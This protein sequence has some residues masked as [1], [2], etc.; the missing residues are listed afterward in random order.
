MICKKEAQRYKES[1][2]FIHFFAIDMGR[3][4]SDK[5]RLENPQLRRKWV[6]QLSTV[7]LGEGL[8]NHSMDDI[9]ALLGISKATLYK[10][11]SSRQEILEDM[12]RLKLEELSVFESHL[13]DESVPFQERYFNAIQSASLLLAGISNQFLLEVKDMHNEL[14]GGIK[15]FQDYALHLAREFYRSGVEQGILHDLDPAFLAVVDRMFI[16]AVSDPQFLIENNL[17]LHSAF[18]QYFL[19][20]SKGIFK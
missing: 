7:Y 19:M 10:H 17:E 14:W 20:K 4:P 6:K 2:K 5:I 12:V 13:R 11:F 8:R 16:R 3:K 1:L 18:E 15:E 9:A